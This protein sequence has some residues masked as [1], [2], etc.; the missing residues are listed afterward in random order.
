MPEISLSKYSKN[1]LEL[2]LQKRGK[3][4]QKEVQT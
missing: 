3:I 2:V 4:I 1:Y